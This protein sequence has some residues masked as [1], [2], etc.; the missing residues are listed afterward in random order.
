MTKIKKL[1]RISVVFIESQDGSVGI[2]T[3]CGLDSWGSIP[4][5]GK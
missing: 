1:Y 5:K 3:G 4:G 2:A